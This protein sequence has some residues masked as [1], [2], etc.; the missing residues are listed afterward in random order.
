MRLAFFPIIALCTGA[1]AAAQES[2]AA[3]APQSQTEPQAAPQ[4]APA[5]ENVK[6]VTYVP[7]VVKEELRR[8][9]KEEVLQE[10]K[11]SNW[12]APHAYPDWLRRISFH[13]DTRIRYEIDNFGHGNAV[14]Y[15]P[16]FNGINTGKPFDILFRDPSSEHWLNT[17]QRRSRVRLRARFDVDVDLGAGFYTEL[18]VASGD[19]P[20][21]VSTNQ[22]IGA[23]GGNFSK[24]QIWLDRAN[25]RYYPIRGEAADLAFFVGR[26]ENPF[27]RTDLTWDENINFDGIAAKGSVRLAQGFR[28]FLVGGAFPIFNTAFDL[29]PEQPNKFKSR[30]KWLYAGQ[31]GTEWLPNSRTLVRL[32]LSFFFF[33]RVRGVSSSECDTNVS[34]I[35][36]DTDHSRPSF[37]QKGNTY[38]TL[39]TP[40]IAALDAEL[41]NG[42]S[43]YQFFGL[44]T[45]FRDLVYTARVEW[46][47]LPRVTV[48]VDGEFVHNVA[49]Q[50]SSVAPQAVNNF[51]ACAASDS[52]CRANPPYGGGNYGYLARLTVGALAPSRRWDW[53]VGLSYRYLQSDAI[54]DA[55][56]NSEFALGGTNNKGFV[57]TAML[58]LADNLWFTVRWL[59][60]DVV[61]GPQYSIDVLHFDLNVRY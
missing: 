1:P 28:P 53:S 39:R 61:V 16:D 52:E 51:K 48:A 43:E 7:E 54:A 21:P 25:I 4:S 26:F 57:A 44:P 9:V 41:N 5:P 35:S 17:S 23:G 45:D 8:E 34:S 29:P 50:R 13:G 22:T 24:Y 27:F 55:F 40:S 11:Q 36:C 30:D 18:R 20:I 42:A 60:S 31:V 14:D 2:P 47:V 38:R 46:F 32:G 59:S 15:Y 10:M 6:R 33:D 12:A 3:N 49:F 56:A 58:A 19:G 37:A